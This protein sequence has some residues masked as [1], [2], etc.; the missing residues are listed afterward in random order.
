[1]FSSASTGAGVQ[2][3][4]VLRRVKGIMGWTSTR[5][6]NGWAF[7]TVHELAFLCDVSEVR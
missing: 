3:G 6:E 5:R 2:Y 4:T 1:M 7:D